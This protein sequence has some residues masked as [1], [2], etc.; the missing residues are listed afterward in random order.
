MYP[1]DSALGTYYIY[2]NKYVL[3]WM[4]SDKVANMCRG[5]I[6]V[7]LELYLYIFIVFLDIN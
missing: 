7:Y 4:I 2:K 3:H 6:S 1:N 5:K